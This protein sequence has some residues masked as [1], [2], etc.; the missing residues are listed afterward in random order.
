G[1]VGLIFAT[2]GLRQH[3]F[4]EDVYAALVLVVLATTLLPPPFLRW[5]LLRLRAATRAAK[6]P[7]ARPA[8]GWLRVEG[9]EASGVVELVAEPYPAETLAVAFDAALLLGETHRPGPRLLDWLSSLPDEP[10][11]WDTAARTRFFEVLD[12][13]TPRSWRFLVVTGLLDRALPELGQALARRQADPRELD[14]T[15]ALRWPTL[16]RLKELEERH[17]L[18]H[19]EGLLLGAVILDSSERGPSAVP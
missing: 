13:G 6:A 11:R 10:L 17:Q 1:E 19:P 3:V 14:P 4:G 8:G 9:D 5:R 7:T 18:H 15:G 12:G 16:T 2:L